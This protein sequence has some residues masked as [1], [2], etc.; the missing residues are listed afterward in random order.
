MLSPPY[1]NRIGRGVGLLGWCAFAVALSWWLSR[2]ILVWDEMGKGPLLACLALGLTVWIVLQPVVGLYLLVLVNFLL[3]RLVD[4]GWLPLSLFW[5]NDLV[6]AS[7]LIHVAVRSVT[8]RELPRTPFDVPAF[9]L[10]SV[11]VLS[12]VAN[13]LP[14]LQ[15]VVGSRYYFKYLAAFYLILAVGFSPATLRRLFLVL[16]LLALLQV[17]L[18]ILQYAQTRSP[19]DW[20][21]GTLNTKASGLMTFWQ[22]A[23]ASLVIGAYF[24]GLVSARVASLAGLAVIPPFLGT[25]QAIFAFFPLVMG[26]LAVPHL[27]ARNWR[28][29]R[30]YLS[31]TVLVPAVIGGVAMLASPDDR[32]KVFHD[33][34][35]YIR[36]PEEAVAYTDL[37]GGGR[38]AS[39][40]DAWRASGRKGILTRLL[41]LGP[42]VAGESTYRM[43][44]TGGATLP[45]QRN[46]H[47]AV[48]MVDYLV[49]DLGIVGLM[50]V[51]AM[52]PLA[53]FVNLRAYSRAR[54]PQER[55]VTY[56]LFGIIPLYAAFFFYL[57]CWITDVPSFLFWSGL[58]YVTPIAGRRTSGVRRQASAVGREPTRPARVGL[59]SRA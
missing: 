26:G 24:A 2:A 52:L 38:L 53:Y 27:L 34:T 49:V 35:V 25:V 16:C 36:S 31:L 15:I 46:L 32:E 56:A 28:L 23:A 6:V 11:F 58:A 50:V 43:G 47:I 22:L 51:L 4:S 29:V 37:E 59:T 3:P 39:F 17:P 48:T 57:P 41:G 45:D 18:C 9:L 12:S 21:T 8:R 19:A 55:V 7:W 20:L 14:P 10:L 40:R 44:T 1:I 30:R 33:S 54:T 42:G 13:A 5:L